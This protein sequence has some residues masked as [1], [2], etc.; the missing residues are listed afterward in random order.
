MSSPIS[1]ASG[2]VEHLFRHESG[3]LVASLTRL[4]GMHH[5]DLAEEIVQDTLLKALQIWPF[6]MPRGNPSAWLMR[7]AKNRAID[8]IRQEKNRQRFAQIYASH[9]EGRIASQVD[10]LITEARFLDDQLH[11]MFACCH[12][13]LSLETQIVVTLNLLGGLAATEIAAAFLTSPETMQKRLYRARLQLK[14]CRTDLALPPTHELSQRLDS[15]LAVL[16]LMFNEGYNT[17]RGSDPIRQDLCAEALRLVSLLIRHPKLQQPR[18]FALG[19]LMCFHGARLKARTGEN[20]ENFLLGYQNR[21]AWNQQLITRGFQWLVHARSGKRLSRYHLEAGIAAEHCRAESLQATNWGFIK[22][23]YRLLLNLE[24][25]PF[26]AL[27]HAI[28]VWY[29]EGPD[30]A[31]K[32]LENLLAKES[33]NQ[34]YLFHATFGEVAAALG[35]PRRAAASY[36]RAISLTQSP[37]ARKILDA[38][39]CQL[40]PLEGS[41][42]SD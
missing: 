39:L 38:K 29:D 3:K 7:V 23:H 9:S 25:S 26:V 13:G 27:N 2:L 41:F 1:S 34:Y 5:V 20:G 16:Y 19:A 14:S 17:S 8:I 28:A 4:L 15:V 22:A 36:H 33:L 6:Q 32:L 37:A 18:V 12:P 21:K 40:G 30:E 42:S 31:I 35:Q 11:M 10:E 24:E